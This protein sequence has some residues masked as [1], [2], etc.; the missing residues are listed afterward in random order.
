[1]PGIPRPQGSKTYYGHRNG[2]AVLAESSRESRP[3]HDRVAWAA[4][5]AWRRP[6][7]TGVLPV[8]EVEFVMPRPVGTPKT[9]TRVGVHETPQVALTRESLGR[10]KS[11][12]HGGMEGL[13][14]VNAAHPVSSKQRSAKTSP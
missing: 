1:V 8:A 7:L 13:R 4:H 11:T 14:V 2:R 12:D 6:L 9:L 5:A 10:C 3:F